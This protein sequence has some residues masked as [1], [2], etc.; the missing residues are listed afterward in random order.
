MHAA[1][2][3]KS[4]LKFV[5]LD[6]ERNKSTWWRREEFLSICNEEDLAEKAQATVVELTTP[7]KKSEE[8]H[9]TSIQCLVSQ[10]VA[11]TGESEA[12]GWGR[13]QRGSADR[14][15]FRIQTADRQ[16]RGVFIGERSRSE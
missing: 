11:E 15:Y 9:S 6:K 3:P 5:T 7:V 13:N 10:I 16:G 1:R 14:M 4:K 12:T 8:T 2:K